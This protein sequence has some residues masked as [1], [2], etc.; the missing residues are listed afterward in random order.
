[1]VT[2]CPTCATTYDDAVCFTTCPHDR[3]LSDE[4]ARRKDRAIQLLGKVVLLP[5]AVGRVTS[6]TAVGFVRLEGI[7]G[8]FDPTHAIQEG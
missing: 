2:T 4:D 3:F 7:E 6:V 1:M 8:E 5:A